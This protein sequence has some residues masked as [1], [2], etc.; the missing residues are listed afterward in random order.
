[1]PIPP[2]RKNVNAFAEIQLSD[3]SAGR[4]GVSQWPHLF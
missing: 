3:T 4:K 2:L 1:M